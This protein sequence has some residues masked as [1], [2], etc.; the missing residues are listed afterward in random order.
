[1]ATPLKPGLHNALKKDSFWLVPA[2]ANVTAPTK[3]EIEAGFYMTCFLTEENA[4]WSV[5]FN[6]GT[7]PRLM[8]SANTPEVLLPSTY[9]GADIIGA[10]DPQA[11]TGATDKAGFEFL[12]DGFRGF[13]VTRHNKIN[14]LADTVTAGE[15]VNVGAVDVSEAVIDKSATTSEGVYVYKAGVAVTGDVKFDVAVTAVV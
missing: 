13:L 7:A 11:A 12:K 8:C 10:V 3:A 9:Q 5:T 2:I 6:K 14:D 4:G 15:F 1:M